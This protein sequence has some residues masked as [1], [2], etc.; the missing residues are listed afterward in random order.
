MEQYIFEKS[1]VQIKIGSPPPPQKRGRSDSETSVSDSDV[2]S[3][4]SVF[5]GEATLNTEGATDA[6]RTLKVVTTENTESRL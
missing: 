2:K 5:S 3:S 1:T 4:N 6:S